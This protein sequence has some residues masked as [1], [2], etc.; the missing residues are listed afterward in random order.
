M[1]KYA[2]TS[3]P[4]IP[5]KLSLLRMLPFTRVRAA[6]RA[7]SVLIPAALSPQRRKRGF[8]RLSISRM[9]LL[10]I[11]KSSFFGDIS[12]FALGYTQN[13]YSRNSDLPKRN[14]SDACHSGDRI[15]N[16][17]IVRGDSWGYLRVCP[18]FPRLSSFNPA[19]S[20]CVKKHYESVS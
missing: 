12:G 1:T 8:G 16:P 20:R 6:R 18:G 5:W 7:R 15:S 2:I 4:S 9:Q 10:A 14:V 19:L 13:F 3:K 17:L 11:K